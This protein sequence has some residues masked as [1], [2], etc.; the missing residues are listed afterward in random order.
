MGKPVSN[1][2]ASN[3]C[4]FRLARG[5]FPRTIRQ[6]DREIDTDV[7]GMK[8]DT[9]LLGARAQVY[10]VDEQSQALWRYGILTR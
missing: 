10:I 9:E 2:P 4:C 3:N 6:V 8:D 7:L 5:T 1:V